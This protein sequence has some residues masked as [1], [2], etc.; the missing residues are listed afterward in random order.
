MTRRTLRQ[1]FHRDPGCDQQVA[2]D[3]L[4]GSTPQALVQCHVHTRYDISDISYTCRN[5]L[6]FFSA[7][8]FSLGGQAELSST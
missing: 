6:D 1:S 4:T 8:E 7:A 3:K 2:E 5:N